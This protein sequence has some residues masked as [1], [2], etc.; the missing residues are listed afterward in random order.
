MK[1][2][3]QIVTYLSPEQVETDL[4]LSESRIN[5][6]SFRGTELKTPSQFLKFQNSIKENEL[7][8]SVL[9][10]IQRWVNNHN[11]LDSKRFTYIKNKLEYLKERVLKED[12][13]LR[14]LSRNNCNPSNE[15]NQFSAR[16]K[17]FSD[18]MLI[19][20]FED[21]DSNLFFTFSKS[22][23]FP[24]IE[25]KYYNVMDVSR[26]ELPE[27]FVRVAEFDNSFHIST[28]CVNTMFKSGKYIKFNSVEQAET[29]LNNQLTAY[30][31]VLRK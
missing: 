6:T 2:S 14:F 18:N 24:T 5:K 12:E 26:F 1:S 7:V 21:V 15:L 31:V 23:P 3:L 4:R 11:V 20:N 27:F 25:T 19:N 10:N 16:L 28:S 29:I 8:S 17:L 9:E 22:G 30:Q 13:K